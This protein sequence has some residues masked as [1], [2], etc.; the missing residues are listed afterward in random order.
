MVSKWK[1]FLL[2]VIF[3]SGWFLLPGKVNAGCGQSSTNCPS[4]YYCI[5]TGPSA[6]CQ[7]PGCFANVICNPDQTCVGDYCVPSSGSGGTNYSPQNKCQK[8]GLVMA[9]GSPPTTLRATTQNGTTL[10]NYFFF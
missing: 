7:A 4:G 6:Y 8:I 1:G 10:D 5:G 2:F 9:C 3:L